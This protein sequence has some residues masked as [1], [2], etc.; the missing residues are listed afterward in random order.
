VH[1][2]NILLIHTNL[3]KTFQ[4]IEQIPTNNGTNRAFTKQMKIHSKQRL[5]VDLK[6]NTGLLNQKTKSAGKG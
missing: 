1:N 6:T 4:E 5:S 2:I 3:I